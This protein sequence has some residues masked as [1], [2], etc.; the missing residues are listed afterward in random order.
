M[1]QIKIGK[2][3]SEKRKLKNLTQ[4][5]LAEKLNITDR[6]VSKWETGKSM[7]DASIMLQLCDILEITVNDLLNGEVVSMSN[8][9]QKYEQTLLEMVKQKQDSDRKMLSLEWVIGILSVIIILSFSIIA[10]YFE[11]EESVRIILA[12]SGLVI[13]AIGLG[14]ATRIEQTAGYYQCKKCGKKHVPKYLSVLGA[15]HFGRTRYMKCPHCNKRSWQKKVIE[16]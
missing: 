8:Y 1:D 2:F 5:Q 9:D 6:A 7:P 14:F 13:G 3:I 16:K 10:K 12:I 11:M 15:M 4:S